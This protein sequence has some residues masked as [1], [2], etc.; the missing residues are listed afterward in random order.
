MKNADLFDT[1]YTM[2]CAVMHKC[3]IYSGLGKQAMIILLCIPCL[4][5]IQL[6][7]PPFWCHIDIRT[8]V[9]TMPGF[10]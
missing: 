2:E 5:I 4:A 7:T 8:A 3:P 9:K 10:G 1:Y 6:N